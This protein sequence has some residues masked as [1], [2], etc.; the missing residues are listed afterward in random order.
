MKRVF[1]ILPS[2]HP[3]GPIKGAAAL[4]N[5][6]VQHHRT[7]LVF[8][9]IGPGVDAPIDPAINTVSLAAGRNIPQKVGF[10]RKLLSQNGPRHNIFSISFC[11]SA[12]LVNL[13]C[14]HQ[15][16]NCSSIRGNLIKNYQYEF[17]HTGFLFAAFHLFF[18]RWFDHAIAMN[19]AMADQIR[20]YSG[21]TAH[22]VSNFVDESMLQQYRKKPYTKEGPLRFIYVGR[23]TELKKIHCIFDALKILK[24]AGYSFHLD[25]VGD[26]ELY[27]EFMHQCKQTNIE[28]VVTF[29]GHLKSPYSLIARADCLVLPSLTEGVSRSVLE[30]LY[31]GVPC[32][33]RNIDGNSELVT[34][35]KNGYLFERDADISELMIKT[36][37]L[38]RHRL[39][40]RRILLPNVYR[41]AYT[42]QKFLELING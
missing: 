28:D 14:Y 29:H 34:N 17:G 16:V 41:Q 5:K 33:V 30:A 21:K 22:I 35:G 40:D 36:A 37:N 31:L 39:H 7:T 1:I 32:L 26:G 11:F 19:T 27:Q 18:L 20:R 25:I 24:T 15:A 3:T 13:C 6:L 38:S 4:A 2:P 10:Y 23:L 42:T 8:L 9:K 12:D